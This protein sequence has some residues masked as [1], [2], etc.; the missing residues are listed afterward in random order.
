MR[1]SPLVF[2]KSFYLIFRDR[3]ALTSRGQTTSTYSYFEKGCRKVH[4]SILEGIV[5]GIEFTDLGR[6]LKEWHERPGKY[7]CEC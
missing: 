4:A 5:G 7:V 3:R 2:L 1:A 6:D